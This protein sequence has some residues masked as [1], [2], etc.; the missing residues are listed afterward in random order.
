M[1][2][3]ISTTRQ[4]EKSLKR[5]IKRGL[6]KDKLVVAIRLLAESGKL[7]SQYRSHKLVGKYAG[8]WECHIEPDWLLVY[9]IVRETLIL[10][11]I[12]T[13]SHSD[14]F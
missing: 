3:K 5:C 11:L 6:D 14:L 1:S 13:G 7:S 9:K 2:Y 8:L 12:R 10:K 4:F